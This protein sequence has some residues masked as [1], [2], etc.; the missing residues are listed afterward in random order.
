MRQAP[1]AQTA[2]RR[3]SLFGTEVKRRT[4]ATWEAAK[5]YIKRAWEWCLRPRC[6]RWAW[7]GL[8]PTWQWLK[9]RPQLAFP[10]TGIILVLLLV[11]VWY[12]LL[13]PFWHL[14][15]V[16]FWDWY[17]SK[18]T[19]NN[20][21]VHHPNADVLAPLATLAA[22]LG[23]AAAAI[24]A[25]RRHIA[26]T[27]A[28]RQRRI[29]ENYTKAVEQLASEKIAE[30]LGGIYTLERISRESS[31]DY[32]TVM[33]TL[34]AF[35]RERARWES[36]PRFFEKL[37]RQENEPKRSPPT[38]IA[39]VLAVILRRD[40]K[41]FK[42]E[43]KED[44]RFNLANTD[45]RG[46]NLAC[47]LLQGASL[48]AA[49]LEGAVLG[50]AHLESAD[51][52]GAHLEGASLRDAHLDGA[53]LGSCRLE[54]ADLVAAHLERAKL[55]W[56][57]LEGAGLVDAHLEGAYLSSAHLEGAIV[58]NARLDGADLSDAHLE[59]A[60]LVAAHLESANLRAA[61]F[62]GAN[63][64][65][66]HLEGAQLWQA[67][68]EDTQL[69]EANLKGAALGYAHFQDAY[70]RDAHLEGADLRRA[71]DL[72][73][74]MLEVAS[75]NMDTKLPNGVARP[76]HWPRASAGPLCAGG[77]GQGG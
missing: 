18:W 67:H 23:A 11:S 77:A 62:E 57:H 72:T 59:G 63:L 71:I 7:S 10:I 5:P 64:N 24:T 2:L 70:L 8:Q 12:L 45:L 14:L 69:C 33:E 30:R 22:A 34:T 29:T 38:D 75:G 15:L 74:E 26:Q 31:D 3:A 4:A 55:L 9:L 16:P 43:R 40:K 73:T 68:L 76:A 56:A 17:S 39:A 35:V 50:G 42:R 53:Q 20:L 6:S 65:E 32:W 51:L 49:H 58:G 25:W 54:G 21:V 28:D 13:V 27:E 48:R 60:Y 44:W 37:E 19:D 46:A 52:W 61:H 47:A 41:N 36:V 66:A 1:L